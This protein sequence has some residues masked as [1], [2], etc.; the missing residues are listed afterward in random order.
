M[1]SPSSE[2]WQG[3]DVLVTGHTGF[4][5]SW[6]CLW[7]ARMGARVHGYALPA[8][9]GPE[10]EEPLFRTT[11]VVEV[12]VSHN[13]ADLCDH[14]RLFRVWRD[15]RATVLLHLAAQPLV[16]ESY[17]R[18][19]ETFEINVMGTAA[20]L[21]ALRR[22]GR[23]AA[24]V[25]VTTDK[26]YENAEE[27][28]GRRETDPLGGH[29]PYSASKAAAELT[30][31]SW[32]QAFFSQRSGV[33]V[34]T[35]RAGNVIGGGDFAADRLVP[36]LARACRA[37]QVALVRNPRSVRPWQHVLECLSGYLLLAE[38]LLTDP[39]NPEWPSAWNFGPEPGDLRPVS[40]LA[41]SFCASWGP[42]AGWH[43]ASEPNAPLE[44]DF[45]SLCI[46]K[47][48]LRLGWRPRWN[49]DEAVAR[50]AAWYRAWAEDPSPINLSQLTNSQINE[51]MHEGVSHA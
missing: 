4:K 5:G 6:L 37:G 7:L 32:R 30:V 43:H 26:C 18:P 28:W 11:R 40:S 49:V 23:P 46:D 25:L 48:S 13:E 8:V 35:A 29:D 41:E 39:D 24:A 20:A 21:E 22:T 36:D 9:A 34:A 12:L 31:A 50:T 2:F 17:R 3:R 27:I 15:S 44:S 51:Y 45:L 38:R 1:N 42:E 10:G 16:R 47:A 14:E 19:Y 33:R